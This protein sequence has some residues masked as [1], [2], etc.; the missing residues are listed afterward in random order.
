MTQ[1]LSGLASDVPGDFTITGTRA[2]H[3]G[4]SPLRAV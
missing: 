4:V 1:F 2:C 3:H